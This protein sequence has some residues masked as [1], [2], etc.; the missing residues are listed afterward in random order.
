[1]RRQDEGDR[2]G[3]LAIVAAAFERQAN[4]V[5]MRHITLERLDDGG[6]ELARAVALQQLGPGWR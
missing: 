3:L 4:R 5:G 6:I 1:M 2:R